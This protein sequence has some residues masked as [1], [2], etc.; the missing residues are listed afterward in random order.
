MRSLTVALLSGLI[1]SMGLCD[2]AMALAA[3]DQPAA[4]SGPTEDVPLPLYKP[5]K[6]WPRGL[7]WVEDCV[8]RREAIPYS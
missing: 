2:P 6:K 1:L 7:A 5:P 8:E 4:P 3:S